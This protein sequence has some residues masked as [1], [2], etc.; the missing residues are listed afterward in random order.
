MNL[1]FFYFK[2]INKMVIDLF[3]CSFSILTS[4]CFIPFFSIGYAVE[5]C[6]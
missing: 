2:G 3:R 1:Q 4:F 5:Y 6:R